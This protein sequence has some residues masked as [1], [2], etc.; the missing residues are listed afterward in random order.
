[1]TPVVV[2]SV[3]ARTS[4]TWS[5]RSRVEQRDEVAAVV[6]RDLGARV[7]DLVQVAVVRVA[8]LAA[9]GERRDPVFGDERGRDVVL[10]GQRVRGREVDLG[11][12]G[13][14]RPHQVRGLRRDVEAGAD[15]QPVERPLALEPLADQAED[16]H[17]ALRPFDPPDALGGEAEVGDVVGG[18]R[19]GVGVLRVGHRRSFSLRL[20]RRRSGAVE[21]R[22]W[23][24]EPVDESLLETDVLDV[25][26]PPIGLERRR[27]VG[28]DVERD[29][30]AGPQQ[31]GR[32]GAGDGGRVAAA[33]IVDVGQDVAD[34]GQPRLRADDVRPRR[35]DE[36]AADA[37]AVVDALGDRR[38]RQPRREPELVEPVEL[39]DL[40]R[41]EPP[42]V[43]RVRPESGP[44]DPHPDHRRPGIDAVLRLDGRQGLGQRGD[45][46]GAGRMTS[47]RIASIPSSRPMT[48]IGWGVSPEY[49]STTATIWSPL[50]RAT[51]A[52]RGE[53]AVL[54]VAERVG[55]EEPVAL[56]ERRAAGRGR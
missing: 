18:Q 5:G 23:R 50:E 24:P 36:P 51:P 20:K 38:R 33:T 54:E 29:L 35:G 22:P 14:Q 52:V 37:D 31:L 3:P 10:R 42:D 56:E 55:G 28:A 48:N 2:S 41:Q 1:M 32:H 16:R 13:G 53:L 45:V 21:I 27:V 15:P 49:S 34:D 40:D 39:A 11:A 47:R 19:A 30:V 46:R 9:T 25:A 7:G 6:H 44:V 43:R 4:L 26:E 12:A 17:L 8:V